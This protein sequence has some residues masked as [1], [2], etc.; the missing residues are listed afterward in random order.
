MIAFFALGI[1]LAAWYYITRFL[2]R[3]WPD[4]Y[5]D[6]RPDPKPKLPTRGTII[7]DE[8]RFE[9][10]SVT[11]QKGVVVFNATATFDHDVT[12]DDGS[13][14]AIFAPDGTQIE[15]G[16]GRSGRRD[17]VEIPA[18]VKIHMQFPIRVTGSRWSDQPSPLDP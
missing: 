2:T 7:Y 5:R 6:G 17:K 15:A 12:V 18:G 8:R 16:L 1:V 4:F 3:T 14:W 9:I 13:D 11:L 10:R